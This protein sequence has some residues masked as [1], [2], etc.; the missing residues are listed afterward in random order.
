[1][2]YRILISTASDL[3]SKSVSL[4]IGL[5]VSSHDCELVDIGPSIG[6][7][8]CHLAKKIFFNRY[9][10]P[11]AN[12]LELSRWPTDYEVNLTRI[13]HQAYTRTASVFESLELFDEPLI[14]YLTF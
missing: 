6:S 11:C 7:M 12:D 10:M 1:M 9:N 3:F 4:V 14:K 5:E 8:G 13:V 2:L